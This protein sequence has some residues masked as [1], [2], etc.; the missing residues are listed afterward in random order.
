MPRETVFS[1]K[2][3]INWADGENSGQLVPLRCSFLQKV[4]KSSLGLRLNPTIWLKRRAH[5]DSD[6]CSC[7]FDRVQQPLSH[8]ALER[9]L[10]PNASIFLFQRQVRIAQERLCLTAPPLCAPG[11]ITDPMNSSFRSHTIL[12]PR[13]ARVSPSIAREL[14]QWVL[15]KPTSN[16]A[17]PNFVQQ[18]S[19]MASSEALSMRN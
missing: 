6:A 13:T 2:V 1:T 12:W 7:C 3:Q 5:Q 8:V 18:S 15:F 10:A 19:I 17:S 14:L 4:A 16:P 11:S 9:V